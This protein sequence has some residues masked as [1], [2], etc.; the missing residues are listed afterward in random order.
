MIPN[1][2]N[3]SALILIGIAI[4]F[5]LIGLISMIINQENYVPANLILNTGLIGGQLVGLVL[6]VNHG[7]IMNT[8]YWRIISFGIGILIIGTLFKIMHWT[9]YP[10]IYLT[11]IALITIT[12]SV[13]FVNKR[14][15]KRLDILKFLWVIIGY[16]TTAMILLNWISYEYS[17]VG[18]ILFWLTLADFVITGLKNKTLLD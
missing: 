6:L 17:I 15:K 5:I 16:S 11:S 3:S 9:G 7:T 13:R 8:L 14:E 4:I 1:I 2:K 10:I 12:Y 18:Q